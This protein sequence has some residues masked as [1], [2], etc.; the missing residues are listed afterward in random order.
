MSS[1]LGIDP[2]LTTG[3][4]VYSPDASP[5]FGLADLRGTD[6]GAQ[7]SAFVAWLHKAIDQHAPAIVAIE[8]PFGRATFTSDIPGTFCGLAHM[9]AHDRGVP[10]RE[11]TASAVKKHIAG[12]GKATKADV[13]AA[14][15]ERFGI[16]ALSNHEADAAAVA[17][18]AWAK[19]AQA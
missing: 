16:G 3:W 14:I 17:I 12:S 10:R 7:A 5:R 2:G 4:C 9:V 6:L 15:R 11:F 18:I 8:R 13:I 1:V 19:E